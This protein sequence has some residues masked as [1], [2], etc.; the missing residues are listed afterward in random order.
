[1]FSQ[2]SLSATIRPDLHSITDLFALA[3]NFIRE[4]LIPFEAEFVYLYQWYC[5]FSCQAVYSAASLRLSLCMC[6]TKRLFVFMLICFWDK[7]AWITQDLSARWIP[8]SASQ[9]FPHLNPICRHDRWKERL[10]RHSRYVFTSRSC[11]WAALPAP[12]TTPM[13]WPYT[14]SLWTGSLPMLTDTP[15]PTPSSLT[16]VPIIHSKHHHASLPE[17]YVGD[18][19]GCVNFMLSCELYFTEYLELMDAQKISIVIHTFLRLKT[20]LLLL[21]GGLWAL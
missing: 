1:M 11:P 19:V 17:R 18:P 12:L 4:G 7:T 14:V 3:G 13:A 10:Y 21:F 6:F 20:G 9:C 2:N 16:L 5:F 15:S 8:V